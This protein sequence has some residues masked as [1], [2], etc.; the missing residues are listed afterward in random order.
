[1]SSFSAE[2]V[3]SPLRSPLRVPNSSRNHLKVVVTG[4]A[5]QIAYSLLPYLCNGE[6][7]GPSTFL[8]LHLLDIPPA[9]KALEGVQMEIE[10]ACYTLLNAVIC[11]TDVDVAFADVDYAIILGGF[12]RRPGMDRKDLIEKNVS[13]MIE[14]GM[15]I[16]KFAK[17][18]CK[19]L[20][21]SNPANTNCLTLMK[22]ASSIPAKNFSCLTRLD[23]DRFKGM[24]LSKLKV[25]SV[26]DLQSIVEEFQDAAP[27]T[28]NMMIVSSQSSAC[29][30]HDKNKSI[31]SVASNPT[32]E[33]FVEVSQLIKQCIVWGNHSNTQYPWSGLM[34][35]NGK[36][37]ASLLE[38]KLKSETTQP[39]N[40][41]ISPI[42]K[43]NKSKLGWSR[44]ENLSELG[45]EKF[46]FD[47]I[48]A[49]VRTRGAAVLEARK[50]SSALSA[51]NAIKNHLRD[52]HFGTTANDDVKDKYVSMGVLSTGNPYGIPDDLIYSFPVSIDSNTG[53]WQFAPLNEIHI[54]DFDK[55]NLERSAIELEEEKAIIT[56]L[57][58]TRNP[59]SFDTKSTQNYNVIVG[60]SE[61]S[62]L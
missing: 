3:A 38:H 54:S 58:S 15:A 31:I 47:E 14:Q 44:F 52:W 56:N 40:F 2:K 1:M 28:N 18:T 9:I 59:L 42:W 36:A 49:R 29:S 51:A 7:F 24:I 48:V 55:Q 20:V 53:I 32:L 22:Y 26:E 37:L 39:R 50:L 19:I 23:Q 21:T 10:D 27:A 46:G 5:G 11:T 12:P 33:S 57:P 16:D 41:T 35:I 61:V 60:H 13:I 62:R 43:E 34:E 30:V 17:K 45:K 25:M 4:G 8:T 6:I